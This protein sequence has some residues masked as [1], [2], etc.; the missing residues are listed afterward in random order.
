M[1]SGGLDKQVKCWD[2]EHNKVGGWGGG[3][4]EGLGVGVE[5]E[6]GGQG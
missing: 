6:V 2:L 5:V 1:F 3:W 4:V